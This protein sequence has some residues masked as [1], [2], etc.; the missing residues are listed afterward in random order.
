MEYVHGPYWYGWK[1][2]APHASGVYFLLRDGIIVY[3]G[4]SADIRTRLTAHQYASLIRSGDVSVE[5]YLASV[6]ESAKLEKE[7]IQ[8]VEPEFNDD[9]VSKETRHRRA[10]QE[11]KK[12]KA[13]A[14]KEIV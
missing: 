5:F 10:L 11:Q 3:I 8:L 4:R 12:R 6:E 9:Y 14:Q 2:V 1:N 13:T 7:L